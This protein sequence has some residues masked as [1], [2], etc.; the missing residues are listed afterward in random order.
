MALVNNLL[1]LYFILF[2]ALKKPLS[3]CPLLHMLAVVSV[4]TT[5][6]VTTNKPYVESIFHFAYALLLLLLLLLLYLLALPPKPWLQQSTKKKEADIWSLKLT[7][8]AGVGVGV[9]WSHCRKQHKMSAQQLPVLQTSRRAICATIAALSVKSLPR[10]LQ[11]PSK[12]SKMHHSQNT[13]ND[14]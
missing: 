8:T 13:N 12:V 10:K 7:T 2:V 4:T 1:P 14:Q 5:I 6:S 11:G 3:F 9:P